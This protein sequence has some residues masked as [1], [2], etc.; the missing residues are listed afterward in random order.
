M[1]ILLAGKTWPAEIGT[2]DAE[3][4]PG[5]PWSVIAVADAA[6]ARAALQKEGETFDAVVAEMSLE[7]G[8]GLQ[9]LALVQ[10]QHPRTLRFL[11]ADLA[12]RRTLAKSVTAMH[13]LLPHPCPPDVLKTALVRA[14][15]LRQWMPSERLPEILARLHKLPSPPEI[16]FRVVRE[17]Q[18]PDSTLDA[19]GE[20]IAKDPSMSAKLLRV[21]NS[22][23]FGLQYQV[24][25]ALEALQVLGTETTKSLLLLAHSFSYFE[26]INS[27][28]FSVEGLWRHSLAV[29]RLAEALAREEGAEARVVSEAFTAGLLHDLGKLVLA[30]NLPEE[31]SRA[32]RL[33][34]EQSLSHCAA[35]EQV[36][37]ASHAEVGAALLGVWGLPLDIVEA[38]ILHHA[39]GW[40]LDRAFCPLSA[41]AAANWLCHE[42]E[43]SG[44]QAGTVAETTQK[45]LEAAGWKE[46]LPAWRQLAREVLSAA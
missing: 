20:L 11:S 18:S 27:R 25:T 3:A 16:Y 6:A 10:Q 41:V 39:P 44:E 46:R 36:I 14:L 32:M 15:T 1:R 24:T 30:A 26:N 22:A 23:A 5:G 4:L 37:G 34:R 38:V 31:Y 33:A 19:V 28:D 21:A 17:L 40:L 7:G 8:D 42:L 2:G 43:A 13:Q 45:C 9:L 35:E 29:G 12:Q